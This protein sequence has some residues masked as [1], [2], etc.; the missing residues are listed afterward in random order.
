MIKFQVEN[1]HAYSNLVNNAR[2]IL[3]RFSGC[4]FGRAEQPPF[5][6]IRLGATGVAESWPECWILTAT[7]VSISW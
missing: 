5:G 2:H 7:G 6:A 3:A 1:Q 4:F